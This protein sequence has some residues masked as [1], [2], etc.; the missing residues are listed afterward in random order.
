VTSANAV[1]LAISA[2]PVAT[3][4]KFAKSLEVPYRILSD[5]GAK[6]AERYGVKMDFRGMVLPRRSLFV[7]DP[8]GELAHVDRAFGV[9]KS[10]AKTALPGVLAKIVETSLQRAVPEKTPDREAVLAGLRVIDRICRGVTDGLPEL[11]P[12]L[13]K[14]PDP[15]PSVFDMV[16]PAR[17][18][19]QSDKIGVYAITMPSRLANVSRIVVFVKREED[20]SD[21]VLRIDTVPRKKP[22]PPK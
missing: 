13:A 12:A 3:Q 11:P 5:P 1:L 6:V 22:D 2:D 7:V 18:F 21:R 19:A 4:E 8:R 9:P 16:E 14:L 20:G 10:L 17:A 15:R